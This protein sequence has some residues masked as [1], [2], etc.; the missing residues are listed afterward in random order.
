MLNPR[1]LEIFV[2]PKYE[3][4]KMVYIALIF[5]KSIFVLIKAESIRTLAVSFHKMTF[6]NTSRS[7]YAS[8]NPG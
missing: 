8:L 1:L 5:V 2:L 4:N 7:F 3:V 6:F